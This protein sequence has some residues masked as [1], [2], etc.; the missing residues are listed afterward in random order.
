[1]DQQIGITTTTQQTMA[2]ETIITHYKSL[3]MEITK[4]QNSLLAEYGKYHKNKLRHALK[5]YKS[6]KELVLSLQQHDITL[7]DIKLA[8]E[9]I[10][11]YKQNEKVVMNWIVANKDTKTFDNDD[12][13]NIIT[14]TQLTTT[15]HKVNQP[16]SPTTDYQVNQSEIDI[17]NIVSP[18]SE[19]QM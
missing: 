13:T 14:D 6:Q 5:M 19:K 7:S 12:N 17:I 18:I 15:E 16:Q 2:R 9:S 1:M 11:A 8:L 3:I 4:V 10:P